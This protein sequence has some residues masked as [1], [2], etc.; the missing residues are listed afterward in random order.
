MPRVANGIDYQ[1]NLERGRSENVEFVLRKGF[2][3][4]RD[5]VVRLLSYVNHGNMGTYREAIHEYEDGLTPVPEIDHH[6]LQTAI[7]YGFGVNVEQ[8]LNSWLTAYGRFGWNE[9]EHES[10]VYTEANESASFGAVAHGQI[11]RRKLDRAGMAFASKALSGDH[12]EYLALGGLG[13]LLG[14][15]RLN[16]GREKIFEAFYTFH[17]WRGVFWSFDLQHI[18]NPGYNR[19]RGPV[20]VPAVRLH[21][22]L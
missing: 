17:L 12:R 3:P 8:D 11:W 4:H 10:F 20:L 21:L 6:P 13:F 16:Y 15:G 19:D 1:W 2:L 7:K 5:G 14:D 22:D 18:N 9:G